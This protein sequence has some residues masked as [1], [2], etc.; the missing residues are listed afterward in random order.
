MFR[1]YF[2]NKNGKVT[3]FAWIG[4]AVF[5]AHSLFKAYLKRALNEWYRRFYDHLG[6]H[7]ERHATDFASGDAQALADARTTITED[8]VDFVIIVAPAVLVHPAASFCRNHWVFQW[9]LAL[10]NSYLKRWDT[11]EQTIEGAAQ[12]VHEDTQRLARGIHSV[13]MTIIDSFLTLV[14]FVPLLNERSPLLMQVAL[15]AAVGGIGI[16]ILVGRHLVGLE[17]KNQQVEGALRTQLVQLELD[18]EAVRQTGSIRGA[19][20]LVI[21]RLYENYYRLYKNFAFFGLWLSFYDQMMVVLPYIITAPM[22]FATNPDDAITLGKLTSSMNAFDKVFGS[23]SVI[24][25]SFTDITD[26]WSVVRRLREFERNLV[27]RK[28]PASSRLPELELVD[29]MPETNGEWQDV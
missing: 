24:S 7:V 2:L 20:I 25:E 22:L 27:G 23:I 5:V 4:L 21:E 3:S 18:A 29:A 17:V 14:I 6:M 15:S 8:L 10:M 12:R 11:A 26:F 1:E 28:A 9:R 13:V 16:S 19:F